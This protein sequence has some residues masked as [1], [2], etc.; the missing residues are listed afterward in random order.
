[1]RY[2]TERLTERL[3]D[4]QETIS[5]ITKYTGQEREKF[6]E[7][8]LIQSWIILHL[9]MIGNL[10]RAIPQDFQDQHPEISWGRIIG[11]RNIIHHYFEIDQNRIWEAIEQDL[12]VLK[13][14]I[15]AILNK[16]ESA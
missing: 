12:P 10:A 2:T 4:I 9:E 15:E 5:N 6:D 13:G 7:D 3:L 8:E 14:A 1:L 11:M 16:E